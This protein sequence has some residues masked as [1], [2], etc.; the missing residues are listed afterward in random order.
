MAT[1]PFA[2]PF[3]P[4]GAAASNKITSER[5]TITPPAWKDY[6]FA[7]PKLAP[8]FQ[9]SLKLYILPEG[10]ELVEGVDYVCSHLFHDASLAVGR[11]VYGSIT[12][13]DKTL[14]GVLELHYQTLGGMW[15]IDAQ[16]A[17]EILINTAIN[18]RVTTWEQVVDLPERFPVIDHEWELTDMVGMSEVQQAI[19]AIAT[20]LGETE[21]G[22]FND[23]L[24]D[25]SNPHQVTKDQV[26]LGA[27]PNYAAA[28]MVEAQAGMSNVK[29]MTPLRT[30][31][32]IQQLALVPLDDHKGRLDNPHQVTA[33]QIGLGQVE[34]LPL[35]TADQAKA[36][37]TNFAY[38]TPVR[39]KEAITEQTQ[40]LTDHVGRRD[41]PHGVTPSQIGAATPDDV[42]ALIAQNLEG[43]IIAAD[44]EKF[45]GLYPYEWGESFV[46]G[47]D[48]ESVTFAVKSEF[49]LALSRVDA[50]TIEPMP[51]L[52]PLSGVDRLKASNSFYYGVTTEGT[53]FS[54]PDVNMIPTTVNN[55]TTVAAGVGGVYVLTNDGVVTAYRDA[56]VTTIYDPPASMPEVVWVTAGLSHVFA[57][58]AGD[59]IVTWGDP[60]TAS[61]RTIDAADNAT[62]DTVETG[63]TH[64]ALIVYGTGTVKPIGVPNFITNATAALSGVTGISDVT[65]GERFMLVLLND[66]SLLA[67]EITDPH[68]AATLTPLTLD[69]AQ[70]SQIVEVSCW[71]T[72]FLVRR[73]DG[74]VLAYGDN[75]SGQCD[76]P[77]L[78]LPA[79]RISAGHGYSLAV[80]SDGLIK[81]WGDDQLGTLQP[82][83]EYTSVA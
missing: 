73:G 29:L 18:P 54:V 37:T 64:N 51:F 15:T 24:I 52:P 62:V 43:E 20:A 57:I 69:P 32:A 67:W 28:T 25:L 56:G 63:H 34:D 26:G 79:V 80:L 33:E 12:F 40:T 30:N 75:T 50:L 41:N 13:Y 61:Y 72:H 53:G 38:M 31:Q 21:A 55:I 3:D 14:S 6:Y 17:D 42:R 65:L 11:P 46:E 27:V 78:S 77:A 71:S 9:N 16:K 48:L 2:Y 49:E 82:P 4:T 66:S 58:V 22:Q 5:Q 83:P 70:F 8:F 35:A 81:I 39:T 68:G 36:G 7:I 60:A 44:A 45:G 10:R 1:I 74:A 19:L 76:V 47:V 23:H 59:T